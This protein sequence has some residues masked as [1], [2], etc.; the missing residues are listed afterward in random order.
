[1]VVLE[2]SLVRTLKAL[3]FPYSQNDSLKNQRKFSKMSFSYSNKENY[4]QVLL[5]LFIDDY[6]KVKLRIILRKNL[7]LA[8][9]ASIS[10]QKR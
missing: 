3:N 1:M 7:L 4:Q 2:R 5:L 10:T 6:S 8:M 9:P